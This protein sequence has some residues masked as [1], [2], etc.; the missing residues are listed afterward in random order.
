MS[1]TY[2]YK[3]TCRRPKFFITGRKTSLGEAACV[4]GTLRRYIPIFLDCRPRKHAQ[5]RGMYMQSGHAIEEHRYMPS[6]YPSPIGGSNPTQPGVLFRHLILPTRALDG[7]IWNTKFSSLIG[8][9]IDIINTLHLKNRCGFFMSIANS[10]GITTSH[11]Y[12]VRRHMVNERY[13]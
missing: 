4:A 2:H 5:P 3:Q 9:E 10:T 1:N 12:H 11:K 13:P 8:H 7:S 6:G